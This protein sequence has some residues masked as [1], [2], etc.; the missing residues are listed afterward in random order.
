MVTLDKGQRKFLTHI[1]QQFKEDQV[2]RD[3]FDTRYRLNSEPIA[4]CTRRYSG[5]YDC[6]ISPP[7]DA[8]NGVH[9]DILD[10]K[11]EVRYWLEPKPTV[12]RTTEHTEL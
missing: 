6:P 2:I 7:L 9:R 5:G 11:A 8:A 4:S 1:S 3:R 12:K 10:T